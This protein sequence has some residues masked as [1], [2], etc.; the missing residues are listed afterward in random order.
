[1]SNVARAVAAGCLIA[2]L[3]ALLFG[4]GQ[5]VAPTAQTAKVRFIINWPTSEAGARIIPPETALIRITVR[6][7]T[8]AVAPILVPRPLGE[9]QSLVEVD[10]PPG[11]NIRFSAVAEDAYGSPLAWATTL[12]EIVAGQTNDVVL[13]L[14]TE[15]PPLLPTVPIVFVSDRDGQG[16]VY[17]MEG[18]GVFQ[19]KL[20]S[21]LGHCDGAAWSPAAGLIAFHANGDGDNE[22]YVMDA[23][24]QNLRKL[25]N[26]QAN[27]YNPVWSPDG[28]M[29]AFQ[30]D[31][32]GT[33]DIYV[34]N[35]DGTGQRR[36]TQSTQGA[37]FAPRWD[38]SGS[39]R[40]VFESTR[41]S[42]P[43][44][45]NIE[46][47][48][49]HY[50][51]TPSGGQDSATRLTNAAGT[52]GSAC[53]AP[54]GSRIAFRSQRDGAGGVAD[55]EIWTLDPNDPFNTLVQ[56]TDNA[57]EDKSP[58]YTPDGNYILFNS[59][60]DGDLDI[61]I[62]NAADGS[63]Q[64]KLSGGAGSGSD[65]QFMPLPPNG[66]KIVFVSQRDG[67]SEI[68]VMDGDGAHPM[69]LTYANADDRLPQWLYTP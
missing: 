49:I 48:V 30:S 14:S 40:I 10:I 35:A 56:L 2:A 69:R 11:P 50:T 44:A 46:L 34:M 21:D 6:G 55:S 26:N 65:I 47:Y 54:D 15:Q 27:D 51:S 39:G 67:N 20:S 18:D 1:M 17:R 16:E 62:M 32:D 23:N 5:S 38:P 19:T 7:T 58:L 53:W 3:F 12:Q 43:S 63:N 22:I 28:T 66:E 68:Y 42:D 31:R 9:P 52:D 57:A 36:L 61:F 41:D 4:C 64:T 25:T 37:S 13:T 24:G 59:D 45:L 29:I 8:T 60:R 33:I